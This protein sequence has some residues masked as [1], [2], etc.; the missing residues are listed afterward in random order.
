MEITGL[1]LVSWRGVKRWNARKSL[2]RGV[3][4]TVGVMV[5]V[6]MLGKMLSATPSSQTHLEHT[7]SWTKLGFLVLATREMTSCGEPWRIWLRGLEVVVGLPLGF[8]LVWGNRSALEFRT[9]KP[10]M[11]GHHILFVIV[12]GR[13]M[14]VMPGGKEGHAVTWWFK[15]Y[16]YFF[17]F[18]SVFNHDYGVALFSLHPGHRVTLFDVGVQWNYVCSTEEHHGW[19]A[20]A[21]PAP[22][23]QLS[24]PAFLFLIAMP[25]PETSLLLI[26]CQ[27][28]LWL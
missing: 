16:A 21:R 3:V 23:W 27:V 10:G 14:A 20:R 26:V 4:G 7:G 5:D 2:S 8:G 9:L 13:E 15:Q 19:A 18:L 22:S 1:I 17:C 12:I 28:P 24:W 11:T 6:I 25:H